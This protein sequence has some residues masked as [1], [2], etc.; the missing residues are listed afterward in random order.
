M[1]SLFGKTYSRAELLRRIGSLEQ[2]AGIRSVQLQDGKARGLEA[3][4]FVTGSGLAFTVLPGRGMD[5]GSASFNGASLCWRSAVGD[6]K[7]E[8]FE[9]EGIG[10]LRSFGGGLLTTCGM[11]YAGAPCEDQGEQLGLH[12]RVSNI[13][14]EAV[15]YDVG[16]R[17]NAA[18][19]SARGK[20]RETRVFGENLVLTRTI[21]AWLG[22]SR[23]AIEDEV[24]NEGYERTP[25][26]MLYHFNFG[27]PLL[28]EGTRLYARSRS[29]I[30]R[31][32]KKEIARSRWQ[33]FPA[34][35]RGRRGDR[36]VREEV[37]YHEMQ[38]DKR[39]NVTLVL[40]NESFC[41]GRGL[42]IYLRYRQRELP[43]FVQ[44][45][46]AGEGTYVLGLE[47]A[48]CWVEGRAAERRR[49][50]LFFLRP[51]ESRRF[52]LEVGVLASR[53]E[54]QSLRN[55]HNV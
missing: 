34:P 50:T 14:A 52:A 8:F 38:A 28:D 30:L 49:G 17:G 41:A 15:S 48:N 4:E 53:A 36:G 44:W 42:G 43:R 35:Q 7:A 46:M 2:V 22:E 39:G 29:A 47:P 45:K 11:T 6:V 25:L 27:F 18:V 16:W 55:L 12:G 54:T 21:S 37:F 19:L 9:P 5:I 23:I 20:V 32:T 26:M 1:V 13:P 33:Q 40:A 24:S 10:W 3:L 31:E 51:G